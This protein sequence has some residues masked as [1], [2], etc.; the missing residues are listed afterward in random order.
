MTYHLSPTCLTRVLLSAQVPV[1]KCM[2]FYSWIQ[3]R[4]DLLSQAFLDVTD[5]SGNFGFDALDEDLDEVVSI[6]NSHIRHRSNA[7]DAANCSNFVLP[8][9]PTTS[10]SSAA[11]NKGV[12]SATF[13]DGAYQ[14]VWLK[15]GIAISTGVSMSQALFGYYRYLTQ[16]LP[17]C[18]IIRRSAGWKRTSYEICHICLA[19]FHGHADIFTA[20]EIYS[21][22]TYLCSRPCL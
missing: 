6:S 18:P 14:R 13:Q 5:G 2:S 19:S 10:T 1:L 3:S 21:F 22:P 7:M 17:A 4:P 11:I 12:N 16:G 15:F 8:F 20:L 9:Q